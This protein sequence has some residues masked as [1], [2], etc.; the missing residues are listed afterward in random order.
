MATKDCPKCS[1][2]IQDSAKKCKHCQADL[3]SWFVRHKIMTA[4]LILIALGVFGSINNDSKV[5]D[6]LD[7]QQV[8][9]V[10]QQEEAIVI[11]ARD[12][13]DE[14]DANEIL[15]DEL[16]DGKILEVSGTVSSIG[17]D[18]LD[19]MYVALKT[20]NVIGS[21]QCMLEDSELTK[22]TS[23]VEGQSITVRGKNTGKLMNVLLRGC[24]IQ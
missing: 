22:A 5:S 17:K 8:S 4:I 21:V 6:S 14:Y 10:E 9:S 1:E 20:N 23:L 19:D 15:A 18:I 13:Y 16:Y 24:T 7:T 2:Q 3:R 12:L 11:S